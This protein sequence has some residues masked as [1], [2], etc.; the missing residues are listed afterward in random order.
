MAKVQKSWSWETTETTE[1]DYEEIG[2]VEWSE[3]SYQF[4]LTRVY[5]QISTG[6]LF[7]ATDSGCSCPSP[8]E[9]LEDYELTPIRRMQDWHDHVA[10][11]TVADDPD[12]DFQYPRPTP[13]GAIDGA[14]RLGREINT[15]LKA[16]KGQ[17]RRWEFTDSDRDDEVAARIA[18]HEE[19]LFRPDW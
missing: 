11:C 12:D 17:G 5:R 13:V 16:D 3:E 2:E 7:Y 6:A 9:D 18:Q 4:D 10:E 8:F 1:T 15:L 14:H 19:D